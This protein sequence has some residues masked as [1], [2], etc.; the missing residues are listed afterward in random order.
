MNPAAEVWHEF[1]D[2]VAT[3][4]H[5][6]NPEDAAGNVIGEVFGVAHLRGARD[7]R[8]EGPHDGNEAGKDDG[9]A[10]VFFVELMG[11]NEMLALED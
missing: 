6:A 2:G 11:A 4:D 1:A 5:A 7:R 3:E 10:A 9:F 8:A